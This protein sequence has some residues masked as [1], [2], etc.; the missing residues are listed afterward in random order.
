MSFYRGHVEP[1]SPVG[2]AV[3][4]TLALIVNSSNG[5]DGATIAYFIEPA[6]ISQL[7][8]EE[9]EKKQNDLSDWFKVE[10]KTG[11][12]L[13]NKEFGTLPDFETRNFSFT[14]GAK[15]T[16]PSGRPTAG[17]QLLVVRAPATVTL[18][19]IASMYLPF[20]NNLSEIIM[21]TVFNQHLLKI[22]FLKY[23]ISYLDF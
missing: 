19:G 17:Q 6:N 15:S 21:F 12:I 13:L 3:I 14:V 18:Y 2:L 23:D 20:R 22:Q 16:F 1:G 4:S 5:S 7:P 9:K 10:E 8:T 11:R